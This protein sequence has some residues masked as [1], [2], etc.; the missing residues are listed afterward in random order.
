[1]SN[2]DSSFYKWLAAQSA[3]VEVG[4]GIAFVVLVAPV[5]LATIAVAITWLEDLFLT[6]LNRPANPTARL[7]AH[8]IAATPRTS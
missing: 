4:V 1:M 7:G 2:V 6:R 8:P 3:S 5:V